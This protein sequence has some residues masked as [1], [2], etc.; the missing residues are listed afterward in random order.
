M[1]SSDPCDDAAGT[2]PAGG[3]SWDHN[4]SAMWSMRAAFVADT[5]MVPGARISV[6]LPS[7]AGAGC[8]PNCSAAPTPNSSNAAPALF[9]APSCAALAVVMGSAQPPVV[10]GA[11]PDGTTSTDCTVANANVASETSHGNRM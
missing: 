3:A 1:S 5:M 2:T 7:D 9:A 10:T 6:V 8:E 11:L 4:A